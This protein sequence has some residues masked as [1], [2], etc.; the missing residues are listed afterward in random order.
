MNLTKSKITVYFIYAI[1]TALKIEP[2]FYDYLA[3]DMT[4]SFASTLKN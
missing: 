3:A 1:P 4:R 2:L